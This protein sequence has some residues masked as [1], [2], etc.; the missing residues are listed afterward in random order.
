MTLAVVSVPSRGMRVIDP[1]QLFA[2]SGVGS[3]VSVPSRGMRVID[4]HPDLNIELRKSIYDSFR[5][6][7]G[8]EGYRFVY[9][10]GIVVA[11]RAVSV[12]SRGMRVIDYSIRVHQTRLVHSRVSVPSRGMRVID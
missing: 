8:Y 7:S 11:D 10:V 9:D 5:P 12:P 3:T 2:C 4:Q 6:L 1:P